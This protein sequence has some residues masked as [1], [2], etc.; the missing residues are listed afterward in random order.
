MENARMPFDVFKG[1]R[2]FL[3]AERD[4]AWERLSA[5]AGVGS[6]PNGLTPDAVKFGPEYRTARAASNAAEL[7]LSRFCRA[8]D[9]HFRTELRASQIAARDARL[10]ARRAARLAAT[11]GPLKAP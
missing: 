3:I 2:D 1:A 10:A 6:G 8:H 5:V 7:A 4:R 9:K 11:V